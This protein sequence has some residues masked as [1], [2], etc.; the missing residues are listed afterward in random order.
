MKTLIAFF[1]LSLVCLG[2]VSKAET[3]EPVFLHTDQIMKTYVTAVGEHQSK[4]QY[5]KLKEH[6]GEL[7]SLVKEFEA[8][9]AETFKTWS[10][11]KQIA[12][13]IDAYNILT[14]KLIVDHYPVPSIRNIGGFLVSNFSNQWKIKFFKLLGGRAEY[15]DAIEQEILRKDYHENRIHFAL[16]CA[17]KSCPPMRNEAYTEAKLDQQLN[18]QKKKFIRDPERNNFQDDLQILNLKSKK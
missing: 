10:Q 18:E 13:L 15:L 8:V 5:A 1:G 14:F 6:H 2:Q 16:V 3:L 12:F 11:N 17:S 7:D 4:V 9:S